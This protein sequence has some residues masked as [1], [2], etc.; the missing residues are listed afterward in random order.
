MVDTLKSLMSTMAD[1]ITRQVSEQV[2]RAMEAASSAR[3]PPALEYQL[4]HKGEPSHRLEGIPSPHPTER[5]REVSQS[6]QSGWL[7]TGQL[8]RR[9]AME[10]TGCLERGITTGSATTST[11]YATHSR[12]T[13][14][15]EERHPILWR[16]TPITAP[17]RQQNSR[18]YCEFHEQSGKAQ[19][20]S[21]Q[22]VLTAD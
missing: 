1:A 22:Q 15:L 13:A 7:P 18:K 2:K 8:R 6:D 14:C 16:L 4:V 5:G 9:A 11:P 3:P 17:P 20:K 10:P 19:L 12:R 21:V